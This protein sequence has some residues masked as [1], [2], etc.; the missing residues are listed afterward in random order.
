MSKG[1]LSLIRHAVFKSQA[2]GRKMCFIGV[3][4]LRGQRLFVVSI[5]SV[6]LNVLFYA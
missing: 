2:C 4:V 1:I 6:D 5:K 3:N